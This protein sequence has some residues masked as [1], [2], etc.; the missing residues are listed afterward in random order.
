LCDRLI[1]VELANRL[2]HAGDASMGSFCCLLSL[3][4]A[5]A[6]FDGMRVGFSSL[7]HGIPDPFR[8]PRVDVGDVLRVLG[9]QLVQFVHASADGIELLVN[10]LF[11][12][13]RIYFAPEAFMAL[14]LQRFFTAGSLCGWS[15]RRLSGGLGGLS[16]RLL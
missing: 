7:T 15:L 2:L 1:L 10:V 11:A 14:I 12:G 3:A 4:S 5:G 8:S 13:E 6:C 16:L 9:S